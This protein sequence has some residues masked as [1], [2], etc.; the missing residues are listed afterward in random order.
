MLNSLFVSF[1]I[2]YTSVIR[3]H[4]IENKLLSNKRSQ[5]ILLPTFFYSEDVSTSDVDPL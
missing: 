3:I 2:N 1:I 4:L 5:F